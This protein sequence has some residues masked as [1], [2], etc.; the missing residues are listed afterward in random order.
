MAQTTDATIT[1]NARET[2]TVGDRALQDRTAISQKFT[3]LDATGALGC[4]KVY[5]DRRTLNTTTENLDLSG[6]LETGLGT[7]VALTKLRL[8][9]IRWNG[10]GTLT[11]DGGVTN[12]A[13]TV[14]DGSVTLGAGGVFVI[15][16]PTAAGLAITATTVDLL[17]LTSTGAGTYDVVI[18]GE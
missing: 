3:F 2:S 16:D 6:S 1:I 13:S 9:A 5:S 18:G 10:A 8:L 11:V 15:V 12:G 14:L 4:P 7:A 17:T